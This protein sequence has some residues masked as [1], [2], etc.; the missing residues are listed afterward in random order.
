MRFSDKPSDFS[1]RLLAVNCVGADGTCWCVQS[2]LLTEICD[3]F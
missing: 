3:E 2:R 1:V